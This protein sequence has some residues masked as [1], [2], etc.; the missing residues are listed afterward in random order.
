[1]RVQYTKLCGPTISKIVSVKIY[2]K[3][4]ISLHP[5]VSNLIFQRYLYEKI[6]LNKFYLVKL[7]WKVDNQKIKKCWSFK[8][9]RSLS[10]SRKNPGPSLS[11]SIR[12]ANEDAAWNL[13]GPITS[14]IVSEVFYT[15]L[16]ISCYTVISNLIFWWFL[17]QKIFLNKFYLVKLSWK[18]DNQKL[19]KCWS[20][21]ELQS[22]SLSRRL[23]RIKSLK[24]IYVFHNDFS[25]HK[26]LFIILC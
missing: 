23:P 5:V 10:L 26:I 4:Y 15:L 17:Y 18:V 3:L 21:R 9:L 12:P 1:M 14:K 7:S 20:F 8:E 22:L 11:L 24:N 19:K 2:T 13:S 25:L 6:F 16:S